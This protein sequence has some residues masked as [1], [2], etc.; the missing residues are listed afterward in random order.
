M[1]GEAAVTIRRHFQRPD[2][3]LIKALADYPT[4]FFADIQGRRGALDAAIRPLF[5][6]RPFVGSAVTV[7][8][9]PDDNLAPYLSLGVLAPGDVLVIA[10][11]GWTGSAVIGDL[12]AGFFRNAGAVAVVTDGMARDVAGLAEV[13]IPIYARGLTPNS[14][15]KNGPG[16]IGG[17]VVIGGVAVRSGDILI[18]DADGVVLLPQERFADAVAAL[19]GIKVKEAGIEREIAAGVVQP[20][21]IREYLAS[22]RVAYRD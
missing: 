12:T 16:E 8:T 9:V 20:D 22:D 15:Q 21:W 5:P 1:A 10:N 2:P 13:G 18:G 3:A 14:P 4:G 7:K 6:S 19:D 17:E 11:G